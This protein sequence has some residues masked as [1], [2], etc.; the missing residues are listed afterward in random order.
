MTLFTVHTH[1]D[2]SIDIILQIKKEESCFLSINIC[3]LPLPML[4]KS[5]KE[6]VILGTLMN[7]LNNS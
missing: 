4:R 3:N 7:L 6:K 2:V 1:S 5:E